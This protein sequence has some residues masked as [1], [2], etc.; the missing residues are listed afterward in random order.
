LFVTVMKKYL[1]PLLVAAV[2]SSS[3]P[4][5]V[6]FHQ[7]LGLQLWSLRAQIKTDLPGALDLIPTYGITEVEVAGTPP[8]PVEEYLKLLQARGLDPVGAHFG[9]ETLQADLAGAIHNAKVLGLRY[10]FV[11]WIPHDDKVGLTAAETH[12]AAANFNKW[13]EAFRAEGI[14]FGYHPH[15]YE[16]APLPVE[17]EATAFDILVN[18][19]KP[20][21]VSFEM[22]VFWVV[23]AGQDPVKLLKRLGDRWVLMH[24]KDIRKGAPTGF[25][26]GHAPDS[27]NVAVGDG[28]IDWPAVLRTAQEVGVKHY[29]LEDETPTPLTCIPASVKYLRALK[30]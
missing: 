29:F 13:G 23:H 10:A 25:H 15:G 1:Y 5:S 21:L 22:D 14:S 18:E 6:D 20:V 9:Y 8:V 26:T 17:R 28:A 24:V 16:F 27:D 12:A 7:H 4:A 11:P 2:A 3:A 19:T 30:L